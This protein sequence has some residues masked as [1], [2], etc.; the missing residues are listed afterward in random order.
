MNHNFSSKQKGN[1]G[2]SRAIL[3]FTINGYN[4][5]LP[6]T[7]STKYDLIVDINL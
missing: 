1:I 4:I 7:E 5:S 2:L 6:L 3:F